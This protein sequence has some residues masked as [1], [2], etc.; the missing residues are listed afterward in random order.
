MN[1]L[2]VAGCRRF[3]GQWHPVFFLAVAHGWL[4]FNKA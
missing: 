2:S 1:E 3:F 4:A